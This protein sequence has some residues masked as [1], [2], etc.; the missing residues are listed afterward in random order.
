MEGQEMKKIGVVICTIFLS[1]LFLSQSVFAWGL[2]VHTYIENQDQFKTKWKT[3]NMNQVYGGLTPDIFNFEFD[4]YSS[5]L[6]VQTH[7]NFMKVWN[8]AKAVPEKALAFGFVSHNYA[9]F[10]A[11]HSGQTFGQGQGYVIAKAEELETI[12]EDPTKNNPLHAA[13]LKALPESVSDI[14]YHILVEYGV[15]LLMKTSS[16]TIGE[17]IVIA[18]LPPNPNFPLILVNGYGSDLSE[19]SD[20]SQQEAD[21][22]IKTA[23]KEF[24][25]ISVL[26]GQALMQDDATAFQLIS[27]QL[28]EF[29]MR[30]LEAY[31][32]TLPEGIDLVELVKIGIEQS[33]ALC[34][35]DFQAEVLATIDYVEN[36]LEAN[37][38]SYRRGE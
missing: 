13:I 31:G 24:Q 14:V 34:A 32:I 8:E 20:I 9:D 27:E 25:K 16:Q 7:T 15:D 37:H 18:A 23:G 21:K 10:T 22:F 26:Y 12:L 4:S 1:M 29:A 28:A 38:I 2:A 36:Q 11:H 33:I 19:S 5:F 30:F 3:M 6:Q 35:P 17:K